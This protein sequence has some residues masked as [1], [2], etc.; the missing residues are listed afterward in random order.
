VRKSIVILCFL[1]AGCSSGGGGSNLGSGSGSGSGGGSGNIL[2]QAGQ[3]EFV[4]LEGPTTTYYVEANLTVSGQSV[5]ADSHHVA[6]ISVEGL[7]L[8]GP[9]GGAI[10]ANASGT[11]ISGTYK[12]LGGSCGFTGTVTSTTTMSGTWDPSC[13]ALGQ[14]GGTFTAQA[15]QPVSGT[16]TG[17]LNAG[18]NT[19]T[20]FTLT[21]QQDVNGNL[22]GS[23][24]LADGTVLGFVSGFQGGPNVIGAYLQLDQA[25]AGPMAQGHVNP[26][27]TQIQFVVEASCSILWPAAGGTCIDRGTLTKQ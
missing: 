21:L 1:L 13:S 14:F 19:A 15:I 26:A 7:Q 2:P 4:A 5:S 16:F 24:Q 25:G 20:Q 11:T 9:G 10:S 27:A 18:T 17:V 22:T 12:Y 8:G 3:W 23:G 6:S